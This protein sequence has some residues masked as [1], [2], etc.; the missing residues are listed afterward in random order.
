MDSDVDHEFDY[1]SKYEHGQTPFYTTIAAEK[2]L[3]ESKGFMTIQAE[4]SA[5]DEKLSAQYND[6]LERFSD[7]AQI[8]PWHG[9]LEHTNPTNPPPIDS[10][11]PDESALQLEWIHGHYAMGTRMLRNTPCSEILFFLLLVLVWS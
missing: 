6:V 9:T 2:D 7:P 10:S 8:R 1:F 11:P 3:A 5:R 4:N